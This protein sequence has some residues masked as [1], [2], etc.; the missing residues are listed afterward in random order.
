[1]DLPP[2]PCIVTCQ[3][4]A[5]EYTQSDTYVA[6]GEVATLEHEVG[7]HAMEFGALVAEALL[8]SAEGAEVFGSLGN[9]IVEKVKVDATRLF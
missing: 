9:Y 7:D 5:S 3:S 4:A 6:A 1:M 2:V 8:A